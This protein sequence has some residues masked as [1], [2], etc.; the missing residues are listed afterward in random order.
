VGLT[1]ILGPDQPRLDPELAEG[2]LLVCVKDDDR[3][4]GEDQL[5][6][7]RVLQQV[8]AELLDDLVLDSLVAGAVLGRQP[9]GVLVGDVR[10]RDRDRA[11]RVHLAGELAGQLDRTHLGAKHAPEGALHEAGDR[12]LDALEQVH[13]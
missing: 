1:L 11:V 10:A 6:T 7:A 4:G 12:C 8:G 13:R 9:H 3:I 2:E 5:L